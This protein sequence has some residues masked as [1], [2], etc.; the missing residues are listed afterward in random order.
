MRSKLARIV[1]EIMLSILEPVDPV[2]ITLL[3][4]EYSIDFEIV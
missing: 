4:I 2:H 1:M 3:H